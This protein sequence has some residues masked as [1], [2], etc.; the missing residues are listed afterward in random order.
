MTLAALCT[1]SC[2]I[3]GCFISENSRVMN[4][5]TSTVIPRGNYIYAT[6]Y[7]RIGK[8]GE[9][10]VGVGVGGKGNEVDVAG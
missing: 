4:F 5:N 3:K 9:V 1:F 10:G 8:W 2:G 7:E 6:S